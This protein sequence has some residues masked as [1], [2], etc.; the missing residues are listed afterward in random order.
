MGETVDEL[1]YSS[2][3]YKHTTIGSMEDLNAA[4]LDDV[5]SFF[6]TYYAPNNACMA[7]VGDFNEAAAKRLIEKYFGGIPQQP[8]PPPADVAEQPISGEKRKVIA[9][10]LARLTRMEV[11]YKTVSGDNP[12]SYAL[13]VLGSILSAGR[14]GRLYSAIVEKQLALN[15]SAERLSGPGAGTVLVFGHA[16]AQRQSRR[17]GKGVGCRNRPH[18]DGGRERRRRYRRPKRRRAPAW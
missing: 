13:Q 12:D 3:A 15:A 18:P 14:T 16:A 4:T 8:A 7:V 9:D 2:F 11:A 17:G 10:K 5:R 1:A 6:K